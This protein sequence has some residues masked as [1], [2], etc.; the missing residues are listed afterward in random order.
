MRS[1]IDC[2]CPACGMANLMTF[3]DHQVLCCGFC[4]TWCE[5]DRET[6][7]IYDRAYIAERYDRYLTTDLMSE[8]RLR[9]LETVIHLHEGLPKGHAVVRRGRLLDVGFGNGSFIRHARERGWDA[10]GYDVNPTE[11]AGVRRASLPNRTLLPPEQRF[12]VV[13]FFDTLEHFTNLEWCP[14]LAQNT[15]WI[16]ISAPRVP[17]QFPQIEWKHRR[18][19]EHH[20]HFRVPETFEVLFTSQKTRA[21]CVYFAAPEDAIRKSLPDGQPNVMTVILRC[22]PSGVPMIG[23]GEALVLG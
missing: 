3:A 18:P 9:V 5:A 11:Y 14:A 21:T 22:T 6:T 17:D 19:G 12:R 16:V 15:D 8:L 4:G 7:A 2:R 10:F 13:S 1:E 20:F 23:H